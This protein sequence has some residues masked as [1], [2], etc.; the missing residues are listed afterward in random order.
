MVVQSK[1]WSSNVRI[2]DSNPSQ[3]TDICSCF[4]CVYGARGIG[5]A[6][7]WPHRPWN[8]TNCLYDSL[9]QKFLRVDWAVLWSW[10][11]RTNW[12]WIV[13]SWLVIGLIGALMWTWY[14][15]FVF[16]KGPQFS[17]LWP[18]ISFSR[19]ASCVILVENSILNDDFRPVVSEYC[20]QIRIMVEAAKMNH[21]MSTNELQWLITN[22]KKCKQLAHLGESPVSFYDCGYP[23]STWMQDFP[24]RHGVRCINFFIAID[25]FVHP[26]SWSVITSRGFT[27][28]YVWCQV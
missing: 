5:H 24:W 10:R 8:S 4:L 6:M 12:I 28:R 19:I 7:G 25:A 13:F 27:R 9:F 2:M 15:T 17:Y 18:T 3:D 14:W 16:H 23:R 11:G 22:A 21:V 20:G 1:V 26:D